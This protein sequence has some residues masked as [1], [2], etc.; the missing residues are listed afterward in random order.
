MTKA[1]N[2]LFFLSIACKNSFV[3][4]SLAF[5]FPIVAEASPQFQ[6]ARQ[7]NKQD[8]RAASQN[9][10]V[11][12]GNDGTIYFANHKGLLTFNGTSWKLHAL[13]NKTILRA[14]LAVSDSMIYT[15]GY[16]ELG[17]WKP[18]KFGN[19][20]YFSLTPNAKEFF[21]KNIEFW[22]IET[23]GETV[24]FH[25]FTRIL[26]FRSDTA[27]Q[28]ILPG[29]SSIMNKINGKILATVKDIGLYEIKGNQAEPYLTHNFFR[30]KLVR[31][32]LPYKN[33]QLLIGTA[34]HGIY[35]WNGKEFSV[36][37]PKWSDYFIINELNREIIHRTGQ[38]GQGTII[39]GVSVFDTDGNPQLKL[40]AQDGL[41]NNTVLGM[42]TDPWN[43]IWVG[44]DD[45]IG[46]ISH[47]RESS[48]SVV[49]IPDV[50]AIY[51]I[52]LH[53][54]Y[55]YL[56]TNQGL[57]VKKE[58]DCQGSFSLIPGTQGQIW[59]CKIIGNKLWA[60]HNQGTFLVD[61]TKATPV[62]RQS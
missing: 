48:F 10:S 6:R 1:K 21:T 43:N 13:P 11:S 50:G 22:K 54:G 32:L 29:F 7:F 55:C 62:S 45:G 16:M 33:N 30:D 58:N 35:T 38:I 60:G 34:S 17:Y 53:N 2:I 24:Y 37:N 31:F 40:N 25:S 57:F 49:P 61:G 42:D 5:F 20:Q 15:S 3:V 12:T 9:W 19:L 8:Y 39:D 18:D 47:R 23:S 52:A 56:G 44:L 28:I 4:L 26:S 27:S 14:V 59:D 36:W 46:F 51:A 41:P